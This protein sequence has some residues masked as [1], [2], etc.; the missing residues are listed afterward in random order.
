MN[1]KT[2]TIA[3]ALAA[4][5]TCTA[6]EDIA[7][8]QVYQLKA[9]V[10]TMTA[11]KARISPSSNP[12]MLSTETVIYR[13]PTTVTWYGFVWGCDCETVTGKWALMPNNES[14]SGAVIWTAS[15]PYSI[16]LLD[17]MDWHVMGA[18]DK[19]G[20]RCEAAWTIGKS[21]DASN[22]FLSFA[23]FGTLALK[24]GKRGEGEIFCTS[25][26]QSL[27]GT[28]SG[29]MP[30]PTY[31]VKGKEAVCTFCGGGDEGTDDTYET[32]E[33][34]NF[35]TCA[36]VGDSTFTAVSGTW[37]MVYNASLSKKLASEK[38]PSITLAYTKFPASVK[39]AI[40]AKIAAVKADAEE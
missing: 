4:T 7:T 30:A 21:D 3:M 38:T 28:V 19:S 27:N 29:W 31:F 37:K 1:R 12:F 11:A 13:K 9:T 6:A 35:C 34:W 8:A 40:E 25:Y 10:K 32:A 2:T 20:D 24:T 18:I 33:S 26:I 16:I 23:G 5:F 39:R 36:K 22:A 17:D 14:V 15:S